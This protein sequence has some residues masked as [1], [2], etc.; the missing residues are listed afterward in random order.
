[1][2]LFV[3]PA[4]RPFLPALARGVLDRFGVGPGLAESVV[5]LPTR[6]AA[7]ALQAAFLREAEAPA[8]LL[9]RLRALAGLSVEDADELSLPALLDLPPAVEP[10]RRQAVLADFAA[11]WPRHR[12]GPPTAEHAW[13][14]GGE[15]GR[16]LDE[17]ALEEAEPLPEDPAALG[18]RW[19]ERLDALAPGELAQ[20]W[21][22]TT[23]FLRGAVEA[24][25]SWLDGQ[26]LLD[27]G[28][29]RVLALRAQ[30]RAWE[31]A[32]PAH[33]VVA[34]GIGQGGTIPAAADLLRTIATRLPQ[35]CV[36]LQGEDA[37]TAA[38]P[39]EALDRAP[40][41]P[42]AGQRA[43]L[44]RLGARLG[45]AKPWVTGEAAPRA[46]LLGAALL[47]AGH[48]APWR[49]RSPARFAPGLEGLTRI[50]AGDAQQEA[51]AIAL[52]LRGA[53]EVPGARAALVTPDR[54]LARRVA[55]ELPRHGILADDSAGQ[56]LGETPAGAFLRLLAGAA[57]GGWRPVALLALLKHPLAAGGMA[58][59][60]WL[61][62]VRGLELRALR[63]PAPGPGL[64]GLRAAAR[65]E[66]HGEA[67]ALLDALEAAVG[68]YAR[69]AG[70]AQAAPAALLEALLAAAEALAA[71]PGLPGGLRLYAQ[72]EGEALARHLAALPP[73]LAE[74]RPMDPGEWPGLFEALLAAGTT[75]AARVARG[76]AG[77]ALHP[78]VEILGLLE[79]RL[80]D[81]DLVV[82]GALDETIWPQAADPGPWMSRAMRTRFGLPSP[83]RR[84]GRVAADFLALASDSGRAVL[85]RAARRGGSPAVPARWLTRL[86]TF[87]SG[88]GLALPAAPE[89]AW[90]RRLDAPEGKP[91]PVD[92]PAPRPPPGSRPRE[93][94]ASDVARLIADP[95]AFHAQR[96]L[97]LAPLDPL[98]QAPGA[99]EYGNLVH[100]AMQRFLDRLPR[101]LPEA[102]TMRLLWEAAAAEA[103]RAAALPP[104]ALALWAPRLARIGAAVLRFEA[105]DGAAIAFSRAEVK[106]RHELRVAGGK[107]TLTAR[108]DRLDLRNDGTLRVVDFKTGT[109][110]SATDVLSGSAPQL[111]LEALIAE[112]GGFAGFQG[113]VEALE[114]W[115]L[116]GGLVEG[117]RTAMRPEGVVDKA[118]AALERLAARFLLGDAPFP[119][120]PHPRRRAAPEYRHLARTDEWSAGEAEGSP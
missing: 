78:Q 87:L 15:L 98:E 96:I 53:L 49:E 31:D 115:E 118:E 117:K 5:L 109:V 104:A 119:A 32:P 9:P 7:R 30:R 61:R 85:S 76:R 110:P 10:L 68:P 91:H 103:L 51:A 21:Q 101:P 22:I 16:L 102:A 106:G 114:Y 66:A 20:H 107:V 35:G 89:A 47:P 71:T 64:D 29:R 93:V 116:K 1:M 44:A 97:G 26:G 67:A 84:I 65:G 12:G 100:G 57:A 25:Q 69:L 18:H 54:D 3:I 48:L 43:L 45:D 75:R 95:Y 24:W 17:I 28:V 108:A 55:A 88:Q 56:P 23:I 6:R 52:A 13:A 80:L 33:P 19:L 74:L 72:A 99:A 58:R 83:E 73:A 82:L 50:A 79:A 8:L 11:R 63:G 92:R 46:A 113:A 4:G 37:L 27:I 59:D 36:V 41:H 38:L 40:T 77:A 39:E 90:A 2:R 14:L 81:F 94:T 34:A 42:M 60:V 105:E 112:R 111:P 120:Q 62:A 86:D 70:Q